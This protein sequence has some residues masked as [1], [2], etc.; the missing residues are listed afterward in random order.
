MA[1]VFTLRDLEDPDG[2]GSRLWNVRAVAEAAGVTVG[3]IRQVARTGGIRGIKVGNEWL[4]FEPSV[5]RWLAD[6]T[7]HKP[8][9]KA[10]GGGEP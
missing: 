9:P 8:G 6:E 1:Q 2:H 3:R 7:A 5:L 4:F 10:S